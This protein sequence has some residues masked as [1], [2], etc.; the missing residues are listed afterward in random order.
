METSAAPALTAPETDA[1][2]LRL[3]MLMASEPA[4]L[5]FPPPAPDVA[6]ASKS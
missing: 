4:T 2:V 1:V 6:F 3:T 5:M